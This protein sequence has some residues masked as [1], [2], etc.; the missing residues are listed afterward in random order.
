MDYKVPEEVQSL[1]KD[2]SVQWR[3]LGVH[4]VSPAFGLHGDPQR[5]KGN[6]F[7]YAFCE[8]PREVTL[9]PSTNGYAVVVM[10]VPRTF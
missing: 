6:W 3:N 10:G 7:F 1:A 5:K 2:L 8:N 9:P 4:S